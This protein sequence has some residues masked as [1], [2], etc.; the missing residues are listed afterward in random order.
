M[1]EFKARPALGA[2]K[3][4]AAETL[5]L[6]TPDDVLA[7]WVAEYR[8]CTWEKMFLNARLAG[9]AAWHVGG[10]DPAANGQ[11]V[12]VFT[13]TRAAVK[14]SQ[15][16]ALHQWDQVCPK[17]SLRDKSQAEVAKLRFDNAALDQLS[18]RTRL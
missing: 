8:Q 17:A 2:G 4:K 12:P 10:A 1:I 11:W 3:Q 5:A 6:W 7:V 15:E 14:L 9:H 16:L 18:L 13:N